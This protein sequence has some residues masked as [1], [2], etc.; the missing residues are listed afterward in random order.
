VSARLV[1]LS[2]VVAHGR[3]ACPSDDLAARVGID[4]LNVD[5]TTTGERPVRGALLRAG[6]PIVERTFPV[7]ALAVLEE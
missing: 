4:S 1:D 6:N 7:R 5:D 2:H 3:K